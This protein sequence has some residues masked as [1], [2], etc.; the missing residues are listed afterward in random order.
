MEGIALLLI[1]HMKRRKMLSPAAH[2]ITGCGSA[3]APRQGEGTGSS[4]AAVFIGG[5]HYTFDE[6]GWD[7]NDVEEPEEAEAEDDGEEEEALDGEGQW[8][9]DWEEEGA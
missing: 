8:E 9:E 6:R 2:D 4:I 1:D 3:C 7:E 5:L